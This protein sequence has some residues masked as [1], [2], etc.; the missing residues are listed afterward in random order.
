MAGRVDRW[1]VPPCVWCG[2]VLSALLLCLW[3]VSRP[4][5]VTGVENITQAEAIA[6]TS[7]DGS[8]SSWFGVSLPHNLDRDAEQFGDRVRYHIAWPVSIHYGDA[9]QAHLAL[10][11]PRVGARYQVLLNGHEIAQIGWR[12][13]PARLI[14]AVIEPQYVALPGPLLAPSPQDNQ[15]DILVQ[16]E[17]FERSGLWPLQLGP[18]DRVHQR[19]RVLLAWQFGGNWM[20]LMTAVLMALLAGSLWLMQR[21]RLYGLIALSSLA[22]AVWL[23][24]S[25][26][27]APPLPAAAYFLLYRI[28]FT[29]YVGLLL[30]FAEELFGYRLQ[31]VRWIVQGALVVG[32]PW[33]LTAWRADSMFLNAAWAG[34]LTTLSILVMFRIFW[35]GRFGLRMDERQRLVMCVTVFTLTTGV[36]DFLVINLGFAGDADLRWMSVGAI[37]RMLL[38]FWVLLRRSTDSMHEVTRLNATLADRIAQRESELSQTFER[39][40]VSE[41]QRVLEAERRRL[42]RDMHDGL[43]SQL[44]QTLN[45]V[46][47][48]R[49][50]LSAESVELMVRQALEEL[51]L[52]LDSLEPMDGDLPTI[53]GTLRRRI[54]PALEGAGI[55]LDWQ[56]DEVEPV[57]Q[58]DA[59]GV[60][61]LFRCLQE[62]FANVAKHSG[63]TRVTVR[64][65]TDPA[66]NR[67]LAIEDN[68]DGVSPASAPA[69]A[70]GAGRGLKN[71]RSRADQIGAGVRFYDVAPGFGIELSFGRAVASGRAARDE[72]GGRINAD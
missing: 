28:V 38:L 35:E 4:A 19:Y 62:I 9:R 68:G 33:L 58:L 21:D 10:L 53:L 61:N 12:A 46:R 25:V 59:R 27:I 49:G 39:L 50:A 71:I 1:R 45:M 11:L 36:R 67:L 14:N 6:L 3:W 41:Q 64:T 22:H 7:S 18:E 51:R 15:L 8:A 55:E 52:M 48:M 30:L 42:M 13:A 32:P 57:S 40:R 72:G 24:L 34:M 29:C 44:V 2:L 66:G 69:L 54:G 23:W 5:S 70:S 47:N 16:R 43:G 56:V 31:P 17:R 65:W 26:Q 37:V 20:M 60:I 63:A